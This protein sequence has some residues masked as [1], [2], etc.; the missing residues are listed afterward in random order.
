M[1]NDELIEIIKN[2][3]GFD[4]VN[5]R[6]KK[7]LD[8]RLKTEDDS[9]SPKERGE[10]HRFLHLANNYKLKYA[11]LRR[12]IRGMNGKKYSND[13]LQVVLKDMEGSDVEKIMKVHKDMVGFEFNDFIKREDE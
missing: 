3:D 6:A 1:Q 9:L 7:M 5:V 10:S 11:I 4:S 12:A 13:E 2:T 8:S